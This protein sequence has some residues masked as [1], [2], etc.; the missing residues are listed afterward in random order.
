MKR[1]IALSLLS[2]LAAC[3]GT[4]GTHPCDDCAPGAG[5][6]AVSVAV[7]SSDVMRV[8]ACVSGAGIPT[9]LCTELTL[10]GSPRTATGRISNV[11]AGAARTVTLTAYP[12]LAAAPE[13]AV[14]IYR[15]QTQV[16]VTAGQVS[17]AS[18][19]IL[20]VLGDVAVTATFT[21]GDIDVA[22]ID[23]L[24]VVVAGSRIADPKTF[25]LELA[26]AS[27]PATGTA[28]RI[29]VGLTRS[30]TVTSFAADN[31]RLHQGTQAAAVAESGTAVTVAMANA[32]GSGAVSIDGGFC[33]PSCASA[34]CGDDGCGGSCGGCR[35]G[36]LCTAG[37]C[38]GAC[39]WAP[40]AAHSLTGAPAGS[41]AQNGGSG[42]QGP[43]TVAGRT[44]WQQTSDWNSL[45]I[46]MSALGSEDVFAV[47]VDFYLAAGSAARG[48]C[49]YVLNTP[50]NGSAGSHGLTTCFRMDDPAG[51]STH[52][53]WIASGA[54]WSIKVQ[55]LAVPN[56]SGAWHTLRLQ[57]RRS[58]CAFTTFL[59]GQR[60]DDWTGACDVAGDSLNLSS[61]ASGAA[62]NVAWSNFALS[63]GAAACAP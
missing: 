25:Y 6:V 26:G 37:A 60:L 5:A 57:G 47:E 2:L 27:G 12:A 58:T 34:V 8:V 59:D 46:P 44:A 54:S 35:P 42:G 36:Q 39:T 63:K 41:T 30:V 40:V 24:T 51:T 21:S 3:G 43:A 15:G 19:Q 22:R 53:W 9:P 62:A 32:T 18:L 23:H 48:P 14:A 13:G 11:P 56:P 10:A 31:T 28:Q 55:P 4:E 50:A 20:P 16:A 17:T 29:P 1:L 49:L 33:T 45:L 52:E 7:T 61:W 38:A